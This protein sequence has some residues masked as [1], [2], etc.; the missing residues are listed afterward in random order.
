[1]ERLSRDKHSSLLGPFISENGTTL[2]FIWSICEPVDLLQ[3]EEM[4]SWQNGN[5]TK[6]KLANCQ[7]NKISSLQNVMSM[8]WRFD[9]MP[10]WL[11]GKLTKWQVNKMPIWEND[12]LTKC[13]VDK[14]PRM[15]CQVDKMTSWQN[16]TQTKWQ[17]DQMQVGK[18]SSLQNVMSMKWWFDKMSSWLICKLK[19]WQVD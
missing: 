1:M 9:K 2:F 10:R 6:C 13:W 7:V 5:L 8:K 18:L 16:A 11:I 3:A 17:F 12:K 15:K 14:M 19:K 4:P